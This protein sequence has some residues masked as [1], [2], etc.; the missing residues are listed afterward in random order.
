MYIYIY[1][2][3]YRKCANMRA[4]LALNA[5]LLSSTVSPRY[6]FDYLVRIPSRSL[7]IG[8]RMMDVLNQQTLGGSWWDLVQDSQNHK[9]IPAW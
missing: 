1:I 2:Y 4:S 6:V 5:Q 9:V 3:I 8:Q 7:S